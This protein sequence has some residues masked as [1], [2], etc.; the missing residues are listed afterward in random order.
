MI[1]FTSAGNS[2]PENVVNALQ[3]RNVTMRHVLQDRVAIIESSWHHRGCNSFSV[4]VRYAYSD[5][6]KRF[7]VMVWS[8]AYVFAILTL[9]WRLSWIPTSVVVWQCWE[10]R[11]WIVRPQ[12]HSIMIWNH[13]ASSST[14][15]NIGTFGLDDRHI[16]FRQPIVAKH[17]K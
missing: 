7:G 8:F 12:K 14:S 11:H 2:T 9:L 16:E 13:V 6:T 1:T 4:I 5:V 10:W 15:W 17:S 3:F